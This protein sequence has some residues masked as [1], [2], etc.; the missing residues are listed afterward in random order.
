MNISEIF[1]TKKPISFEIFPPKG[2]LSVDTLRDTIGGF[3]ALNP[4]FISVTYSAGGTGNSN[5]T[6]DL[7]GVI[8]NEYDVEAMA[9]M[10][11]INSNLAE[12][13]GVIDEL[14]RN[15]ISNILALRGD[16]VDDKDTT[17]FTYAAELISY[18][19]EHENFCIG[20]ACYPEGHVACESLEED[21][22]HLREKQD[23]GADFFVSQLF[24]DNEVFY[25]FRDKAGLAGV[26]APITPGIMPILGK[27]QI[28]RMIFMCGTSLPSAV[29]RF[30]NKY[31]NSPEDLRKAGIEYAS[32]QVISLRR[33]GADGV[34]IYAMNRPENA[35][36][37]L[38]NL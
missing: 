13:Q 29:I 3:K 34:H 15:N 11:C 36:E 25:R 27:T 19:K 12:I 28:S 14:K 8:K 24:F 21:I 26:T 7:A 33:N 18:L 6:V 31:E 2:E 35:K 9:H 23:A 16:R 1:K 10:T 37:I 17:D 22:R 5:N 38:R 30:L 32:K 4:D 20:A